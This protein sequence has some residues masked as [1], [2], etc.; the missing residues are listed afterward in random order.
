MT[1]LKWF[2]DFE[3]LGKKTPVG[4]P[5]AANQPCKESVII[6]YIEK[7]FEELGNREYKCLDLFCANGYY[8]CW[9]KEKGKKFDSCEVTAVDQHDSF[10]DSGKEISKELQY[11]INFVKDDVFSFLQD[12][13]EKGIKYD[14]VLCCGG[15]YHIQNPLDMLS[16]ITDVSKGLVIIQ[17]VIT[18]EKELP[19]E[20]YIKAHGC[21]FT[22]EAIQEWMEILLGWKILKSTQNILKG[23]PKPCDRGSAYFLCDPNP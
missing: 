1:E 10:L 20:F 12:A 19:S 7:A 4:S 9:L 16:A 3:K 5:Y 11:D 2:H 21:R 14:I 15:L 23:N 17:S 13:I 8:S 22:F 18:I 6:P